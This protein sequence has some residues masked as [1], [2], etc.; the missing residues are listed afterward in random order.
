MNTVSMP[1]FTAERSMRAASRQ[2]QAFALDASY[3]SG[4]RVIPQKIICTRRDGVL[5]C[6]NPKCRLQ[7]YQ[8]KK[9]A[10]LR[11]CLDDC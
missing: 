2:Y 11:A 1:G 5:T 4:A 8:T 3:A 6:V 7:C 10:D 9:G